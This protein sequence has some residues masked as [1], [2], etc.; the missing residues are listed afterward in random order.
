MANCT[1]CT[2][3]TDT[4]LC[5]G[6]L[7]QIQA[8]LR[9]L[10]RHWRTDRDGQALDGLAAELATTTGRQDRIG[11]GPIGI[12]THTSDNELPIN[13]AAVDVGHELRTVLST[14]VRDL[15]ETEAVREPDGSLPPLDCDDTIEAMAAWLE[16]HPTWIANHPTAN[17]LYDSVTLLVHRAER[18]IDRPADHV[19]LGQCTTDD[20]GADLHAPPGKDRIRCRNCGTSHAVDEL[21]ERLLTQAAQHLGTSSEVAGFVRMLGVPCTTAAI[22][23]HANRGSLRQHGHNGRG[24]PLYQVGEV[25]QAALN[26]Q[27][28][29][30]AS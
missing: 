7:R 10:S 9:S 18:L 30:K 21:R 28:R 13:L 19:P 1:A 27:Q 6:C 24:H 11:G 4:Y 17:K 3:P 25:H 2:A 29:R 15:W 20:C 26:A 8:D 14:W 5:T 16:R 22:R 23:N 12:V